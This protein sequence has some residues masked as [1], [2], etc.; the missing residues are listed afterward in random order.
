MGGPHA[1]GAALTQRNRPAH[2]NVHHSV[3]VAKIIFPG[4]SKHAQ[5]VLEQQFKRSP[6][7]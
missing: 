4:K 6:S 1:A 3:C 7:I 5:V 2:S